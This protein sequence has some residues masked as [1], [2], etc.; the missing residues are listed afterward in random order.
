MPALELFQSG[1]VGVD[2]SVG[3]A[4]PLGPVAGHMLMLMLPLLWLC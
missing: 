1:H 2:L 3:F 4:D